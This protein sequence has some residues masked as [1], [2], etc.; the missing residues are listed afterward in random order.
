M[1]DRHIS[2]CTKPV[3]E[4]SAES[5]VMADEFI[6]HGRDGKAQC[7]W[8]NDAAHG[9]C[10]RHAKSD[11][12]FPLTFTTEAS[13]RGKSRTYMRHS[14]DRGQAHQPKARAE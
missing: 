1:V 2:S 10:G 9:L 4:T 7:L 12:G 5:L 14:L 11:G 6:A 13:R 3:A 8:Q